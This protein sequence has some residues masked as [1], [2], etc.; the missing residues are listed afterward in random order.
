[1]HVL[2]SGAP[3]KVGKTAVPGSWSGIWI[4]TIDS[5]DSCSKKNTY[6]TYLTYLTL[7]LE[8]EF[9]GT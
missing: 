1:M 9:D 2:R 6:L 8:F 7:F 4:K 3:L 5:I